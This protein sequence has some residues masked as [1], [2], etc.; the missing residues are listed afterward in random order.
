M[1]VDPMAKIRSNQFLPF[2]KKSRQ[3]GR[4]VA[5]RKMISM[6]NAMVIASSPLLRSCL[7]IG[8]GST[9]RVACIVREARAR[10]TQN[11]LVIW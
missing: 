8:P 1:M 5:N 9:V 4:S 11:H 10:M 2:Q 3:S 7:W 6:S